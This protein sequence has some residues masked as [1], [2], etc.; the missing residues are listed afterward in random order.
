MQ[1]VTWNVN[2]IRA[3]LHRV[4]EYLEQRSPDVLCL[5]ETKVTDDLFPMEAVTKY[6][7]HV[8][9]HGQPTYNGVAILSKTPVENVRR[10]F[11]DGVEDSHA[12]FIAA[13]TAGITVA[14]MYIPNGKAVGTDNFAYKL[15]WL[16]RAR[17]WLDKNVTPD[18][19]AAF[20][21]DY[22][23][24][25]DDRDVYDAEKWGEDLLCHPDERA[26]L[27]RFIDFGLVDTFRK[28]NPDGGIFTWWDYR[29]L[30]FPKNRGV[31]IDHLYLTESLAAKTTD[32]KVDRD[33][34]KGKSPSDH[35]PVVVTLA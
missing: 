29:Q 28:H 21:G 13:E 23:V 6:G 17:L 14:S 27:N 31:R 26:A 33:F 1:L 10:G 22:N 35:A 25:P 19:P 4:E 18:V 20:L 16:E 5:Q 8:A 9:H 12:R 30:A 15:K 11:E 7:Y 32:A 34:R 24:A 3:R 2:S